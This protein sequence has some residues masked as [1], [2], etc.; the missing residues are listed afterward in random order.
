MVELEE[1]KSIH[2]ELNERKVVDIT[3][4]AKEEYKE[5]VDTPEGETLI[6]RMTLQKKGIHY[7]TIVAERYIGEKLVENH[8]YYLDQLQD[9]KNLLSTWLAK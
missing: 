8:W 7:P 1:L 9:L 5:Y 2:K 6:T 4:L 3:R